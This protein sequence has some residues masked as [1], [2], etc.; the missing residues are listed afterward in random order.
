MSELDTSRIIGTLERLKTL[1]PVVF[2]A[3]THGFRMNPPLSEA[4]ALAFEQ[5][6]RIALPLDYRQFLRNV[7]NGGA[8]PFYG[9]FPLGRIDDGMGSRKWNENDGSVGIISEHFLLE[10]AW[11]DLSSMPKPELAD[12]N[13]AEYDAQLEF[14]EKRY[15]SGTLMNGAIPIC[16]Q[17]C[18]LRIWLVVTGSQAGSL[19]EDRRSEYRG[20]ERIRLAD[21]SPGTFAR[22]YEQWLDECAATADGNHTS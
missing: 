15:W 10:E 22:W 17:G 5:D 4:E 20:L 1:R 14:F 21:G 6:H 12:Q 19:W 11:N 13:Q 16:H 2:G 18:A 3:E 7:G 8:G 9:V